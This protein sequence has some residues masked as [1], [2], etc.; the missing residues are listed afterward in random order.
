MPRPPLGEVGLSP[1]GKLAFT[2]APGQPVSFYDISGN[3]Y[4]ITINDQCAIEALD[5]AFRLTRDGII[6][7]AV[8]STDQSTIQIVDLGSGE[9]VAQV[10]IEGGLNLC[11][12]KDGDTLFAGAEQGNLFQISLKD[13][14]KSGRFVLETA[15][16]YCP[17]LITSKIE[18]ISVN[19]LGKSNLLMVSDLGEL[20]GVSREKGLVEYHD[21]NG[22]VLRPKSFANNANASVVSM[23][24][25]Q[26]ELNIW[27]GQSHT[28]LNFTYVGTDK[29]TE[30]DTNGDTSGD[31]NGD[32]DS[33]SENGA[34]AYL[35]GLAASSNYDVICFSAHEVMGVTVTAENG[36]A[37]SSVVT[38][39][40]NYDRTI[41]T[42]VQCPLTGRIVALYQ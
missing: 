3:A 39:G 7:A 36:E 18:R 34:S 2:R 40:A 13:N 14:F 8:L 1:D 35:L 6:H 4:H 25:R 10:A 30:S 20:L 29:D 9:L 5:V 33:D 38:L 41:N 19:P 37:F 12:G 32:T 31:T 17:G 22:F 26:D 28:K 21:E 23:L 42:V 27:K 11:F 16:S 24:S 15:V